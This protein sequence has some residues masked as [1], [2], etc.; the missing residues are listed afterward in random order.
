MTDIYDRAKASAAR[1]LAPRSKG[2][3]GLELSLIR[4]TAGEYDPEIG[5]S[6]VTT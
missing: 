5:G 2:G 6:P 3:K 1:M 4:I